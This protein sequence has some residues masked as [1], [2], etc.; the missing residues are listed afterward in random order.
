MVAS[1]VN[2]HL[3]K[4]NQVVVC[5]VSSECLKVFKNELCHGKLHVGYAS[6]SSRIPAKQE[7]RECPS[8]FYCSEQGPPV[9]RSPISTELHFPECHFPAGHQH[10]VGRAGPQRP[11]AGQPTYPSV[12]PGVSPPVLQVSSSDTVSPWERRNSAEICPPADIDS[13]DLPVTEV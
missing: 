10:G 5:V 2:F 4:L 13:D 12:T 7:R 6:V 11:C 3:L 1:S 9:P 8:S